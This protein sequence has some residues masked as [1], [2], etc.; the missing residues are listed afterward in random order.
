MLKPPAHRVEPQTMAIDDQRT[1][2][3]S[4]MRYGAAI[5]AGLAAITALLAGVM[6]L[7]HIAEGLPPDVPR[8]E[9][10][11]DGNTDPGSSAKP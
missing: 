11:D 4:R 5:F 7:V 6:W 9:I 3:P 10:Y 8:R 1:R 2:P